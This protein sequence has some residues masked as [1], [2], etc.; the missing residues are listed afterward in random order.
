ME[1]KFLCK[2][3]G[4]YHYINI[5]MDKYDEEKNNQKCDADGSPLERVI[6]FDGYIGN[7]GGYDTVAG[8]AGWQS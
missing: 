5:P 1:Y 2:T 3:C 7:T 6:E 8:K 4:K